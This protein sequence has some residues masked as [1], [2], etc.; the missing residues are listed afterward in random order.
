MAK[1]KRPRKS[2]RPA[3]KK[4]A[5]A[6]QTSPRP[7]PATPEVVPQARRPPASSGGDVPRRPRTAVD[8]VLDLV[9]TAVGVL[10]DIADAAAG[11]ITPRPGHRHTRA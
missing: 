7:V 10:L 2:T 6:A 5:A 9:R 4:K 1:D 3:R 8:R 11:T